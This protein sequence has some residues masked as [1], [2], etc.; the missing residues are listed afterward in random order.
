MFESYGDCCWRV[1]PTVVY[2]IRGG[3]MVQHSQ[4][5]ARPPP[6]GSSAPIKRPCRALL[7]ARWVGGPE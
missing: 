5:A 2:C 6:V 7:A 4:N 1:M 3:E